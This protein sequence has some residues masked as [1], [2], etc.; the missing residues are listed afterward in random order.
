MNNKQNIVITFGTFDVLHI[1]HINILKRAA[2]LKGPNGKL[3][4]G[5]SSDKLNFQKKQR[6]PVYNESDRLEIISSIK[7]VDSV[8]LEESLALKRKYI[9]DNKADILVMG[10]DW[11]GRFDEYN[12]ICKVVYLPRTQN[13]ST[14]NIINNIQ[15]KKN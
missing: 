14:T 6:V 7:G 10:D 2:K 11:Y 12:D 4:V 13:I 8:F 3:I 5:V 9:L 1:G 15:H